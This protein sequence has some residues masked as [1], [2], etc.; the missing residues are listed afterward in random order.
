MSEYLLIPIIEVIFCVA[1][2]MLL[3]ISGQRHV[4]RKPFA[5]FLVLMGLWG[6]FIFMM[7]SS[8]NLAD[9]FVWELPVFVVI[10]CAA[11]FFYL[12]TITLTGAEQQKRILY[13]LCF[14]TIVFLCLIPTR[15]VVSD[16]QMMWYGK[17]PVIG[18]LFFPY[19]LCVYAPI[20]LGLRLL[21]KHQR[22][23]RVLN[24][25]I[26]DSYII[27]GIV[28][29][30]VGGTT[31][32]LPPLGIHMYPLGIV[33][34]I[35]F[36]TLATIAMLKYGLFEIKIIL[37]KVAAHVM[38]SI[39]ILGVIIGISF[40]SSKAFWEP[41]SGPVLFIAVMTV[42]AI[43]VAFRPVLTRI[44]VMVDMAFYRSRYPHIQALR[45]FIEEPQGITDLRQLLQSFTTAIAHSLQ[46]RS[47]YLMLPSP[48]RD[49]FVTYSYYGKES[50]KDMSIPVNSLLA[51]TA[52]NQNGIIDCSDFDVLPLSANHKGTLARNEIELLLPMK[53]SQ[54][55]VGMLL[56]GTK[57]SRKVYSTEERRLLEKVV[58]KAVLDI[59]NARLYENVQMEHK[60]LIFHILATMPN[61]VVV[62]GEDSRVI[63][64]N[65]AFYGILT[66]REEEVEGKQI[67][68]IFSQQDLNRVFSEVLSGK[69]PQHQFEF[70][71][72]VAG[73]KKILV[74]DIIY[75]GEKTSL[76]IL[77]DVT[78]ERDR[79]ERAYLTDRLVSVGEMA[80]GIA[81]ELNNPLTTIIGL[82]T[83][84]MD[85]RNSDDAK[86]DIKF[87]YDEAQRSAKIVKNLLTFAHKHVEEKEP[88][89][90]NDAISDVLG[91]RA[92]EHKVNNIQVITQFDS[93]LPKIVVDYFQMQQ[94]FLNIVLN[95]ESAMIEAHNRGTLTIT[96]GRFDNTIRAS[97]TDDGPGLAEENINRLFDP[98]FTTK[99][100]GKGTGLGLSICYG[101]VTGYNGKIYAKNEP[102]K[103]A[104]FVVDLPINSE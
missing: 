61:A 36:C 95:A 63:L 67:Q 53:T 55:L 59:E 35:V 42:I 87:I 6:L 73:Y 11:L 58:N 38:V 34:N 90:I 68:E 91:L 52:K 39:F 21:L 13:T 96:T 26:R 84:L 31:D 23:S 33:A 77:N 102:G 32:Y 5:L 19:V 88:T 100:V 15:L 92:Y 30:L 3:M 22:Q 78:E 12:F 50:T 2:L 9:S 4:A 16:M 8:S 47:V 25:R 7:R 69:V 27:A 29:M 17:A 48:K 56:L 64:A 37:R 89:Q 98:F 82:S 75:M 66:L 62:V 81:H 18:P 57:L 60:D 80:S 14:F 85:G 70:R 41:L 44:E 101:I 94:V 83:L 54:R 46:C 86:E 51:L 1:L 49:R 97:F 71:Q 79:Q 74:A 104:A 93:G 76:V 72:S 24:E 45:H 40:F 43:A 10:L 28:A 20:I 103:G 65:R 99:D